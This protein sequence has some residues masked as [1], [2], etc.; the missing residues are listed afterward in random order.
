MASSK[1]VNNTN[2]T[3][4][5]GNKPKVSAAMSAAEAKRRTAPTMRHSQTNAELF[6]L[7]LMSKDREKKM[8]I[9][10]HH[11]N[12]GVNS[13]GISAHSPFLWRR[14]LG[15][16]HGPSTGNSSGNANHSAPVA[17]EPATCVACD[18]GGPL[19]CCAA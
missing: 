11:A 12:E 16:V 2:A 5:D 3:A 17:V 7:P 19:K 4:K 8:I 10:A 6:A 18:K 14:H 9:A 15:K 1:I 13:K